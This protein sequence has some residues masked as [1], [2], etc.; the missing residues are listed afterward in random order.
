ML[1][2]L[3]H[4]IL[5]PVARAVATLESEF[6][7]IR[8]LGRRPGHPGGQSQKPLAVQEINAVFSAVL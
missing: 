3:S 4:L 2:W 7:D 6:M 8:A 5:G 1:S